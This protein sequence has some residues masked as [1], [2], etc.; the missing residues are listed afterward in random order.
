MTNGTRL[1][2]RCLG[3]DVLLKLGQAL[4]NSRDSLVDLLNCKSTQNSGAF[5]ESRD[6]NRYTELFR[7]WHL[8]M[9][10]NLYITTDFLEFSPKRVQSGRIVR[11][12]IDGHG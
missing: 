7:I 2:E 12:I 8:V 4:L 3:C 6:V 10:Q 11:R 1:V 5:P 9:T